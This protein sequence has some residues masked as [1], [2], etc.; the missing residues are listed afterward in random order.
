MLTRFLP[1]TKPARDELVERSDSPSCARRNCLST[2]RR[3][4]DLRFADKMKTA[5]ATMGK[6][7]W[8]KVAKREIHKG[9]NIEARLLLDRA[10][11]YRFNSGG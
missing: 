5:E 9:N 8:R 10:D 1:I 11:R 3:Y 7:G 4:R 6:N 2:K